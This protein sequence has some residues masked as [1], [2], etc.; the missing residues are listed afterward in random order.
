MRTDRICEIG[1]GDSIRL[2]RP[3]TIRPLISNSLELYA[4][5][6]FSAYTDQFERAT[7]ASTDWFTQHLQP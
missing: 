4:G 1:S 2:T 7:A 3:L 5:G 6:H